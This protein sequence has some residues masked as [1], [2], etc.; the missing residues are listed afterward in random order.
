MELRQLR[1]FVAVA[2]SRSFSRAAERL[3]I[4]QP[5]LSRQ[6][7]N[8]E[9]ELG[10]RLLDRTNRS[11]SVTPAGELFLDR[12]RDVLKG[13]ESAVSCMRQ[14]AEGEVGNLTLGFG[15][16]AAYAFIPAILRDFRARYPGVTVTLD[17]IPLI[18][19]MPALKKRR[20]DIGF[21]LLPCDDPSIGT[22][23][24]MRDRLVIAVPADHPLASR[25]AVHLRE[26]KSYDFVGFSRAG[27]FG[28]HS[29]TLEI[30]RQAGFLPRI[31]KESAPMVSVIGLVASSIGIAIVPSM[32]RR[33]QM[34]DVR[35]VRLKDK[36][37]H[38]D[39]AFAWN[40]E[41]FSPVLKTFL[42]VARETVRRGLSPAAKQ[43]A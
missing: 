18:E 14:V 25:T 16:S 28:Y 21:V 6:V 3:H 37:A 36:H 1:Y 41:Q 5:P 22:E 7:A 11:V 23:A 27:R 20:I 26:L 39:F 8:L 17:Q 35:Y 40:K 32:A 31:V 34:A 24:M 13:V 30:C 15:G 29:H 43:A 42:S 10:I 19:Q 38:M 4:S 2:D 9:R 33:L 12:A